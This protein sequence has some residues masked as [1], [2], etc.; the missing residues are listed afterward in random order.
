[1][2]GEV[3]GP[4]A[5]GASS[6]SR[7]WAV[8]WRFLRR[9]RRYL[10]RIILTI[11]VIFVVSGAKAMQ[12]WLIKPVIDE[13]KG[14]EASGSGALKEAPG[15]PDE[16]AGGRP[17]G[18]LLKKMFGPVR[19]NLRLVG[20]LAILLSVVMFVFGYLRD[21][22][23]WYLTHR[24]VA[25]FRQDVAEHLAYLPLRFHYDRKTGDLISRVTNDVAATEPAAGF[26]FDDA[27]VHSIMIACAL[28]MV[29]S[30]NWLLALA[31][32]VFFPFYI[33]PMTLLGR[34]M[35]KARK[36]SLERLGDMTGTMI[37]T[38]GGIKVVKA[39]NME[40]AQVEEFRRHNEGY[41]G[42]LMS[43]LRRK[44][45]SENL[46]MLFLGLAIALVFVGG[47]WLM[48]ANMLKAGELAV[49]ALGVAMINTSARELSK[50]YNKLVEA[51]TGCERIFELLDQPREPQHD[52]GEDL[53]A[54]GEGVEFRGVTFS[55]DGD[56]VLRGV[57]LR[58]RP[59]EVLAVVGRSG[60]G[61]TTLAD[62]LCGFYDPQ[63][64]Q[65]LVNGMDLRRVRRS[66][67]LSRIAVV[68]QDVF[69]FNATIGENIRYGRRDAA[70]EEIEA[71][72]RAAHIHDFISGLEKGYDT[73]VGERGV[74]LSGGQRQRIAIARA[75]LRN[76]AILI[77][78]EATSALDAE[79]EKA[80][81]SALD[82]LIRSRDRITL[83]IAHRLTT[84]KNADRV[85][86]LDEGMLVEEGT[87]EE[88][89]ARGGVYAALYRTQFA[90]S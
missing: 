27:I 31:A 46:S 69:L 45:L 87:H 83:I 61:K 29:F 24:V 51:S 88:L 55:Y 84:I 72:A 52:S 58:I 66:S 74:K 49:F 18:G 41:L 63:K 44:A 43:A 73:V 57:S 6:R 67:L 19:W 30:A 1:M 3:P 15:G 64:G 26:Y 17:A 76:P 40:A 13:L 12:G 38:F 42:K 39:F 48:A 78:D 14:A 62:L 50:S 65:V 33:V 16:S 54:T 32:V 9:G 21:T 89:L 70:R 22:M 20:I 7:V 25:D 75:I 2:S 37:Q 79:S 34:R 4:V 11:L 47:G 77:L 82:D 71:A 23:T 86:V 28:V 85:A 80:V 56:P 60:A 53:P 35:R 10:P 5:A 59:G 8:T 68:T 90:G 36:R 81:Q